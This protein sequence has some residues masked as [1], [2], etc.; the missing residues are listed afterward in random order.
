M[1]PV[2][3]W[4]V[5]VEIICDDEDRISDIEVGVVNLS[6]VNWHYGIDGIICAKVD[7][8]YSIPVGNFKDHEDLWQDDT[9]DLRNRW[10]RS[11]FEAEEY[12]KSVMD[13]WKN[14]EPWRSFVC[15]E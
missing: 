14:P 6:P 3:G 15:F 4:G 7:D 8:N 10:F 2:D 11:K 13:T 9:H 12:A 1:K 5:W